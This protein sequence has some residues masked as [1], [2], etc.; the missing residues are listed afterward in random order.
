MKKILS[1]L[2][3][4]AFLAFGFTPGVLAGGMDKA[5][6]KPITSD[7]AG[8]DQDVSAWVGKDVKNLQ[9]EDLGEVKDFVRDE[10]GEISLV[11][12]SHGGFLGM[13]KKDVAVPYSAFSYNESEDHAV[14]DVSEDQLANAP[15]I[16]ADE[17]L[18]DRAFAEEVYRHFG[19]RPY[20]TDEAG[21]ADPGMRTDEG[22]ETREYY[23]TDESFDADLDRGGAGMDESESVDN[24]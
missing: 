22:I 23:G 19:E 10:N 17:N 2:V 24:F 6:D 1:I 12:I 9:G 3:A 7:A 5:A 15:E 18:T 4:T 8:F 21:A 14:L 13:G 16:G 11:I 20:W